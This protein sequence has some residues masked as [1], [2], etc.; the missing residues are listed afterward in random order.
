[1][2]HL[3]HDS[4]ITKFKLS[5]LSFSKYFCYVFME[6]R[7]TID[8]LIVIKIVSFLKQP[9]LMVMEKMLVC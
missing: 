2:S 7:V 9:H 4:L 5:K 6:K 8:Q 1:M 3:L